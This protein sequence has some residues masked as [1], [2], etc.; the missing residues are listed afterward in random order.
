M[1]IR[2]ADH[3]T[4]LYPQK[5]ALASLTG[6][7]RSVGQG[8]VGL[9]RHW[10]GL[11]WSCYRPGV[12]QMV[13]RGIALLFRDR[14]TRRWVTGQQ[15]APAALYP[16]ER[17]GTHFTGGYPSWVQYLFWQQQY[18]LLSVCSSNINIYGSFRYIWQLFLG[19][20]KTCTNLVLC[21]QIRLHAIKLYVFNCEVFF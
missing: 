20:S 1:G 18:Y 9:Q 13:G 16:R 4:P 10:I 12:A 6:G 11:K 5:L 15:H 7:G 3:V 19:Q 17:P 8:P 21:F 2:C 14:G